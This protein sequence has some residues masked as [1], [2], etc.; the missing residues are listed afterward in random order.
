MLEGR[1]LEQQLEFDWGDDLKFAESQGQ[2]TGVVNT[3]PDP[4][5]LDGAV[6]SEPAA[7]IKKPQRI[8]QLER[9]L[10]Q[11]QRYIN[12]LKSQLIDQDFLEIQ[13]A[14]TEEFAHIQKQ[15][16]VALKQQL[17]EEPSPF[18][19][20][21]LEQQKGA[22]EGQLQDSQAQLRNQQSELLHLKDQVQQ[23]QEE[24]KQF[25]DQTEKL[26]SQIQVSQ[27]AAVQ[28]TQQKII[29]QQTVERLRAQLRDTEAKIS[30][31]EAT[32]QSRE[33]ERQTMMTELESH[34]DI[35]SALQESDP[36]QSP[37]NQAIQRL[38]KTL[39]EAQGKIS[40]LEAQLSSQS[41][42]QAQLQHTTQE[43]ESKAQDAQERSNQLEQQV[44]EM[45]EEILR[46]AQ[47]A[48]EYETA[49]QHWKDR[50]FKAERTVAQMK[51]VLEQVVSDRRSE[52]AK[53][54]PELA[55]TI[56][57]ITKLT[58]PATASLSASSSSV[59]KNLKLDLPALMH[60]WRHDKS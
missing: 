43:F 18:D 60:R 26:S 7:V 22:L 19:A 8:Q 53:V 27:D 4:Q 40:N 16:I 35:I 11:C 20:A 24:I 51:Q 55:S 14:T 45:Q 25:K 38:S 37:K 17:G 21:T 49:I 3:D 5:S 42:L 33:A 47:Q 10:E 9:A 44:T 12:T 58:S 31:L 15:A 23:D 52:G 50:C 41:V 6:A 34:R 29:A 13:L 39:L 1:R 36:S 28:E 46:Q 32:L 57:E 54:P 48:H 2:D 59:R 30:D 56:T